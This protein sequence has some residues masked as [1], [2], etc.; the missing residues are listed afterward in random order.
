MTSPASSAV[1][2]APPLPEPAAK[3]H[4]VQARAREA[5]PPAALPLTPVLP[6]KADP[7]PVVP[8]QAREALGKLLSAFTIPKGTDVLRASGL[9]AAHT[10]HLEAAAQWEA[11]VMRVP[12]RAWGYLHLLLKA[13][14]GVL[15]WI[16]E[17][18]VRTIAAVIVTVAC[19][20]WL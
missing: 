3:S 18:P 17:S 9:H 2:S 4:G 8:E 16:T 15:D 13:C 10:R 11:A 5:T 14:I 12:R 7:G 20:H 6:P 1:Q 19:S